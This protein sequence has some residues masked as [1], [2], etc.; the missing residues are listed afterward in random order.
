ASVASGSFRADLG[1]RLQVHPRKAR[2]FKGHHYM[3]F[4][5]N[6][7]WVEARR[8][9]RQMGGYLACV[10]SREENRFLKRLA[11]GVVWLGATDENEEGVW[12]WITGEEST[13][14]DWQKGQPDNANDGEDWLTLNPGRGRRDQGSWSDS[15]PTAKRRFV[16][17]WEY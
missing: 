15:G 14:T 7:S 5:K 8:R 10:T 16:C 12:R 17:E 4:N 11:R 13:F 9:C 3:V 1:Y 2:E 6:V